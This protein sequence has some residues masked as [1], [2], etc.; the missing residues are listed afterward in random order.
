MGLFDWLF[1]R[2]AEKRENQRDLAQ[3]PQSLPSGQQQITQTVISEPQLESL[4]ANLE[5]TENSFFTGEDPYASWRALTVVS[6]EQLRSRAE[7]VC[8]GLTGDYP[9]LVWTAKAESKCV[10]LTYGKTDPRVGTVV[11]EIY[12]VGDNQYVLVGWTPSYTFDG[13]EWSAGG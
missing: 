5:L 2:K 13:A 10:K 11:I 8:G 6:G 1:G 7:R 3:S 4:V 12:R 9:G